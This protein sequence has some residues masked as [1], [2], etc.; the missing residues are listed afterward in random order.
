MKLEKLYFKIIIKVDRLLL[1]ENLFT[2]KENMQ[3]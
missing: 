2:F 3:I 1:S